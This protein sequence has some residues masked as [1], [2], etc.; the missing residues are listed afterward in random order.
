MDHDAWSR[1]HW[2]VWRITLQLAEDATLVL[3]F[4]P[5]AAQQAAAQGAHR[6]A[7]AHYQTALH[8]ANQMTSEQQAE[9][10]DGLSNEYYLTGQI[11]EAIAPCEAALALWRALD[12]QREVGRTLRRLSRL[13]WGRGRNAQAE[14]Y[15]LEAVETLETL[16]PDRELAMA[17][18]NM[19]HLS[20]RTTDTAATFSG[21]NVPSRWLSD[22]AITR[23]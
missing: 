8:Y 13:S 20:T 11:E 7:I 22:L 1:R 12:Q 23:R 19:A 18:A 5:A 17:F 16:P 4:A 2:R 9:V 3:R 15:G 10:L 14:R 21:V 6:E